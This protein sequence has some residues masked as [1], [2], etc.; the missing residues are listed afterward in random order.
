[1]DEP[2]PPVER[3][4]FAISELL[5]LATRNFALLSAGVIL[6]GGF[7]ASLF[8]AAY[9]RVFDWRLIW[10][11]EPSDILKV[12]ILS[13]ALLSGFF[14][15]LQIPMNLLPIGRSMSQYTNE[16]ST[17]SFSSVS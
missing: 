15:L 5:D 12:G 10:I 3:A 6:L 11:I 17:H 16:W 13:L 2:T 1:M 4:G 8:L 14:T 9:L 7:T